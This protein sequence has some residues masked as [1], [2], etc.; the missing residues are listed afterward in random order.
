MRVCGVHQPEK[1]IYHAVEV[2]L[3]TTQQCKATVYVCVCGPVTVVMMND[4]CYHDVHLLLPPET[5]AVSN[6][7]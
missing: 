7:K 3:V 4:G 5:D 6:G 2:V 1:L